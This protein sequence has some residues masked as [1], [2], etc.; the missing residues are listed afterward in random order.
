M[1]NQMSLQEK[2]ELVMR[3]TGLNAADLAYAT[4]LSKK[5]MRKWIKQGG[6]SDPVKYDKLECYLD[7]I[8]ERLSSGPSTIESNAVSESTATLEVSLQLDKAVPQT[9]I[10]PPGDTT[11]IIHL[12]H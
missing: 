12:K 8:L 7:G 1:N 2:L 4:G 9:I 10:I 3:R 11:L 6:P 5:G